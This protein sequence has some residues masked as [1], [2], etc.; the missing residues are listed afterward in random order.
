MPRPA[1]KPKLR[2]WRAFVINHPRLLFDHTNVRFHPS[3]HVPRSAQFMIGNQ[4]TVI[5]IA[6]RNDSLP[7]AK[8]TIP[9]LEVSL[10]LWA[11][12]KRQ[13]GIGREVETLVNFR[14]LTIEHVYAGGLSVNS[15]E[16]ALQ[17]SG[18]PKAFVEAVGGGELW[19]N[20][21]RMGPW[22]FGGHLSLNSLKRQL[23]KHRHLA[24]AKQL[25]TTV[26]WMIGGLIIAILFAILFITQ[27]GG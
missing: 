4:P 17:F 8:G 12:I 11:R 19:Q 1:P 16:V 13:F 25:D 22:E 10:T 9:V 7:S 6:S 24:L 23:S 27:N 21:E 18:R 20:P 14:F 15:S 2:P 5:L 26:R 3:T